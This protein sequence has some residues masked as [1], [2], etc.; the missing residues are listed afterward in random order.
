MQVETTRFGVIEV[1][2]DEVVAFA[3]GLPGF[4]E[5]RAMALLGAGEIEGAS[6]A[7]GHHSLFWLQDVVDP[8]LAFL[9]IVP[10]TAYPDYDI[11]I[12]A[13]E[14]DAGDLGDADPDDL[15]VLAIVTARRDDG[16]VRLTSNLLAPVVIDTK[17][18]VGRQLILPDS[19]W[20]VQAPLAESQP[21]GAG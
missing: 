1:P 15:C 16:G 7:G 21:I 17:R 9:T 6:S 10:W 4:Q 2:D 13:S 8:D 5:V 20:P 18:R 19:D 3:D 14:L 12:D 11:D